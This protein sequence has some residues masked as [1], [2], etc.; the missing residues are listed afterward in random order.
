MTRNSDK[1]RIYCHQQKDYTIAVTT[2][3]KIPAEN[4]KR[5]ERQTANYKL[6]P[7]KL[8]W[9]DDDFLRKVIYESSLLHHQ[10]SLKS[11]YLF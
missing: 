2:R 7:I 5:D 3:R 1:L 6:L 11:V 9:S 10:M 8:T 4:T